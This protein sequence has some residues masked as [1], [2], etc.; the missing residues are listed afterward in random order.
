MYQVLQNDVQAHQES[1]DA[2]NESGAQ[3]I[4]SESGAD[5]TAI[6]NKLDSLN[7]QWDDVLTGIRDRQLE[8][9]GSLK[10]VILSV[11]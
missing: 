6:R 3:V 9:E 2:V 10:E 8:L 7:N 1:L 5:A 11:Q 4:A